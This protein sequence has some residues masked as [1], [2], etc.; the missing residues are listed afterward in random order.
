MPCSK[1]DVF[2]S[3]TISLVEKRFL[4]KFLSVFQEPTLPAEWAEKTFETV[5]S[6]HRI[7]GSLRDVIVHAI[8]G[9]DSLEGVSATRGAQLVKQYVGSV[10]RF[11]NTPF[12]YPLYGCSETVQAFSRLAAVNGA[13]YMLRKAVRRITESPAEGSRFVV[14]DSEGEEWKC[15]HVV[16]S[17]GSCPEPIVLQREGPI[18]HC[19][20][21]LLSQAV[22]PATTLAQSTHIV[23]GHVVQALHLDPSLK[24][25]P[26]GKSLV[27]L[28]SVRDVCNRAAAQLGAGHWLIQWTTQARR[29]E[30]PEGVEGTSDPEMVTTD[31]GE[32]IAQARGLFEKLAPEGSVFFPPPPSVE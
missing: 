22:F 17:P 24:V 5:L 30:L 12:L 4:M 18:V 32:C 6:E 20:Y 7:E 21:A 11:G 3:T 26:E 28:W 16:L 14:V 31:F 9:A 15:R 25:C 29:P 13:T 1:A 19:A 23:D 2:Q 10:G 27:F 8:C